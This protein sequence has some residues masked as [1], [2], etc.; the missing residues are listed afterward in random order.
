MAGSL[1]GGGAYLDSAGLAS[2]LIFRPVEGEQL[3]GTSAMFVEPGLS[4]PSL[5]LRAEERAVA[6]VAHVASRKALPG[7]KGEAA[8]ESI[9]PDTEKVPSSL[10]AENFP[11]AVALQMVPAQS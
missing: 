4:G 6:L 8:A 7:N 1:R 5:S 10:L 11:F 9:V 3:T 2:T